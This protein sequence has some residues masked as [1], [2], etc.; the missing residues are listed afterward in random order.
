MSD[1]HEVSKRSIKLEAYPEAGEN[2]VSVIDR[3]FYNALE[4]LGTADDQLLE[5]FFTMRF[6]RMP[7]GGVAATVSAAVKRKG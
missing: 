7:D 3:I 6:D 5:R 2:D 1:N 4:L